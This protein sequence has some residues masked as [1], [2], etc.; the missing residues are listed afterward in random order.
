MSN[1]YSKVTGQKV[2]LGVKQLV[3]GY[4]SEGLLRCQTVSQWLLVK[5]S[6]WMSNN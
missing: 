5:M 4:W 2:F 1:S 3:K 6:S